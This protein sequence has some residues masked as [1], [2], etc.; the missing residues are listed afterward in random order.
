MKHHVVYH[1]GHTQRHHLKQTDS[2]TL[3]LKSLTGC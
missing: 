2:L 3:A 1:K